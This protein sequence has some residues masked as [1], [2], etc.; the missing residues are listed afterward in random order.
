[1]SSP[2]AK[3]LVV[4]DDPSIVTVV[5]DALQS[6]DFECVVEHDGAK[7]LHRALHEA[8][9]LVLLDIGLPTLSGLDVCRRLKEKKPFLPIIMLTARNDEIDVVSGLEVGADDYVD[10]P[11]RAK[12]LLARVRA[13]L[14]EETRK[15][16]YSL[17]GPSALEEASEPVPPI[18][19]GEITVDSERM[20]VLKRGEPLSLSPREYEI[21]QL[22]A[23]NPGRPFTRKELLSCVWDLSS[24][25]YNVNV[26][27]F[28]SR[29]RHKL[30]DD[31]EH[32]KYL[33]TLRGIG[34]RFVE[35]NELM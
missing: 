35:P 1:M 8:F 26:S 30:E 5:S 7:G 12:E 27:V 16:L 25:R 29:L 14:R 15:I 22:L 23:M 6:A 13:R 32:P 4:E 9:D 33:I 11:F 10:K 17:D 2:V 18:V 20:R 31:P 28:M 24:E 19:I 3:I 21:I 34:Y